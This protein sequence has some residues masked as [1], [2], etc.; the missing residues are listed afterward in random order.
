MALKETMMAKEDQE[1]DF[2]A[3]DL[4][5]SLAS[6]HLT[7]T[8]VGNRKLRLTISMVKKRKFK[9]EDGSTEIKPVLHFL[10]SASSLPLN[11]TNLRTMIA[12]LGDKPQ[13][14]VGAVIG[15]FTD[16]TLI[17]NGKPALRVKVLK[18]PEPGP[19]DPDSD[20]I[21]L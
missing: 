18:A 1:E 3:E 19:T 10:E 20:D 14:W 16:P 7:S 11:K 15:V 6:K 9:N 13:K 17:F 8:V 12:E 2:T 21:P 5:K 4:E